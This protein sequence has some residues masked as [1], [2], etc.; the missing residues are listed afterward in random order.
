M[1]R[2][3]LLGTLVIL[4]AFVG[5]GRWADKLACGS[6]ECEWT[7]AEWSR[8]RSL[9]FLCSAEQNADPSLSCGSPVPPDL[10]NKYLPID[11]W[12]T[13]ALKVSPQSDPVVAL[14]R[15]LYFDARLSGT[16]T[17]KDTLGRPSQS[18]RAEVGKPVDVSCASCHDPARYG[19]DFTS[20]PRTIAIGAGWY[21]VNGQSTLNAARMPFLYWNGRSD[22]LWTQAAQVMESP[23]SMNGHRMKTFWVIAN[24]YREAFAL[25]PEAPAADPKTPLV[26]PPTWAALAAALQPLAES[27]TT[28]DYR[29]QYNLLPPEQQRTVTFVHVNAAKAIAAYE[30]LL[31]SDR[32]D[33]D[34]FVNE[35]PSSTA[36]TPAAK[37]GLKLFV[38]KASCI[39][40][41]SS[42]L[43]SDGKFHNIGIPQAGA[44]VPTVA[45]CSD[46]QTAPKCDCLASGP[47]CLPWGAFTGLKKLA[48]AQDFSRQSS[49]SDDA[50]ALPVP[51]N[52]AE[53]DESLKGAWRTPSL[54]DVAMTGPYMHDGTFATLSDVVWHYDQGGGSGAGAETV[55]R[56]ELASLN[57]TA[58]E[59]NDLVAFLSSL[60]GGPL[61]PLLAG[62]DAGSPTT[63]PDAGGQAAVDAGTDAEAGSDGL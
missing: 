7:D 53:P 62:P 59:R 49:F 52:I 38:G 8:V 54:R 16:A 42:P 27:A 48:P 6:Q 40:C 36:L 33:F 26:V 51:A 39:D 4:T 11:D 29:K 25:F 56:S 35:G 61:N 17:W 41:H 18:A 50:N 55:G 45:E 44:G 24:H 21:D 22:S 5:C 13:G 32:S 14:G 3:T 60:T 23:V 15:A 31:T 46:L 2:V 43:L 34:R 20:V 58:D 28:E 30:W 47:T 19:S 9:A 10:S 57:L 37:R 63:V 12:S 1:A